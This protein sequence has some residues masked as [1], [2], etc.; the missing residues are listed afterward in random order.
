MWGGV[1]EW[2]PE[3]VWILWGSDKS[4]AARLPEIPTTIPQ[5]SSR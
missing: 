3:L 2:A 5:M 1:A 4:L